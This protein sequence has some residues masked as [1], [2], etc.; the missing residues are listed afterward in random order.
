M[1]GVQIQRETSAV[2]DRE[3]RAA[4]TPGVSGVHVIIEARVP[5]EAAGAWPNLEN[6]QI[7]LL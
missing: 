4:G 3:P 5:G 1:V 2:R 7:V 6:P